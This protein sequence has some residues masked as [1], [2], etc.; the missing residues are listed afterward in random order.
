MTAA[1]AVPLPAHLLPD[2]SWGNGRWWNP[3]GYRSAR[4]RARTLVVL[5]VVEFIARAI[6]GTAYI[7]LGT[8]A[9][10]GAIGEDGATAAILGAVLAV[11]ISSAIA[12][13]TFIAMLAWLSRSV[14]NSWY[15]LGGTPE[16]SPGWSI[17]WWFVPFANLV[18]PMLIVFDLN[19]RMARGVGEPRPALVIAWWILRVVVPY[20]VFSVGYVLAL[21]SV[22]FLPGVP[23][24]GGQ[25]A[26]VFGLTFGLSELTY[27]PA[28]ILQFLLVRRIQ[29]FAE[30][31]EPHAIP[32]LP[33]MAFAPPPPPFGASGAPP[34]WGPPPQWGPPSPPGPPRP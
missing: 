31:R 2:P 24:D 14:D 5:T 32:P 9:G 29:G 23:P 11:V 26:Q 16:W 12:F 1:L 4:V 6:A 17:G 22:T 25:L 19:K 7:V 10:S 33:P 28:L 8:A 27:L 21:S 30:H 3:S 13:A 34:G 15:L 20:V 18:V